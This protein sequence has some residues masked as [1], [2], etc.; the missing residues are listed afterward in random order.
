[1]LRDAMVRE[2]ILKIRKAYDRRY[3]GSGLWWGHKPT[4]MAQLIGKQCDQSSIKS[5]IDLGCGE[6]RDSI[7]LAQLGLEVTGIDISPLGLER[8]RELAAKSDLKTEFHCADFNEL[9]LNRKFDAVLCSGSLHYMP[10]ASRKS[11]LEYLKQCTTPGGIHSISGFVHDDSIG[12]DPDATGSEELLNSKELE[13]IYSDWDISIYNE[14]VIKCNSGGIP[15]R[16]KIA[17]LVAA[18]PK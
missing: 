4:K 14:E 6:G 8:A 13:S 15:H 16:H 9:Q 18:R 5:V 3:G 10:T 1:M 11:T 2:G 7:Y 17:R 12:P